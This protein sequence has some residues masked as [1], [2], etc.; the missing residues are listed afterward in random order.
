MKRT[1][2]WRLVSLTAVVVLVAGLLSSTWYYLRLPEHMSQHETIVL[3]QSRMVPGTQAALRL[4]VRDSKDGHPLENAVLE[5]SIHPTAG[6]P[7]LQL[8]TGKTDANGTAD[9]AFTV[10][11]SVSPE[12]VLVVKTR[13]TLG[14]DQVERPVTLQRDYRILLTSDKPIYQPGQVIHLRTLALGSFDRKPAAAQPLE[15]SVSD[16]KG[17]RVFRQTV[18]TSPYGVASVDFQLANEVNTGSYK[19]S[20]V[21][22]NTSSE[23][24]VQV[25]SYVLPKFSVK[26][27]TERPFYAPGEQV[28]GTLQA[29]YFFGKPVAG[30]DIQLEGYTFDVSRS[31]VLHLQGTTAADGSY[32][33]E[34]PLPAYI[35]GSDLEGG[36]ARFYLQANVTDLAQ[37]AET[38]NKSI[39]VSASS[40]AISALPEG[41][42]VQ[43]GIENIFYVM[44]NAPDGSPVEA[45]LDVTFNDDPQHV[46]VSAGKYGVA[47]VRHTPQSNAIQMTIA[48]QSTAGAAASR[49][50]EFQGAWSE[51]SILLRPDR[52]IYA[53]GDTMRL[54]VLTSSPQGSVYLDI[55]RDGQTISTRSIAVQHNKGQLEVDLTPDQ[56]GTLELH[57]YKILTSGTIVRDT[58]LVVVDNR[59]DLTVSLQTGQP[60]YRPGETAPLT[61]QVNDPN[62]T[63]AQAALGL[64]IVDESVFA[65]AE[66]DPG[67]ARLYF[68]LE[69]EL[70]VPRYDLHGFSIPQLVNGAM[71]DTAEPGLV[72]AASRVAQASLAAVVP[73][74]VSFSL[75][76][77]SHDLNLERASALQTKYFQSLMQFSL[78]L[79]A[80]FPLAMLALTISAL[81][82]KKNLVRS[83]LLFIGLV[84]F[85]FFELWLLSRGSQPSG[86]SFLQNILYGY[87]SVAAAQNPGWITAAFSLAALAA[88]LGMAAAAWRQKDRF[89]GWTLGL[90]LLYIG[91]L[92]L[93]V[94]SAGYNPKSPSEP[95]MIALLAAAVLVP[96]A[97][98]LR[99]SGFVWERRWLN[100]AAA[101][102]VCL[103]LLFGLIPAVGSIP[104]Q[105]QK[106]SNIMNNL[107]ADAL[108]VREGVEMQKAVELPM[109]GALNEAAPAAAQD[110]AGSARTSTT[111]SAVEQ[112]RLRQYFPETMLW[113]PDAVTDANGRLD[114]QIPM[115]DSITTWR[116]T[117]LASSQDGRLGSTTVPLRAFQDF[118]IDLDLPVSLTVGDEISIPVGV[119][120]YMSESQHVRLELADQ[121]WFDL[122]DQPVKEMDIAANEISVVYFQVR[123]RQFGLQAF[124]VTAIGSSLSD[125]IQ[126]QVQVMPNGKGMAFSQSDRLETGTPVRQVVSIPT[127]AIP[128]TQ[129]LLVKIYPGVLSQVVEGLDSILRMPNGCFEQT[130]STTYPNVLVLDYLKTTQKAAPEIQ[131]KAEEYINLGY[132]RLTTFEVEGSG[133]FSLFGEPPADRMLTA[134]G[135]QEFSDMRRVHDVDPALIERAAAWLLAQQNSDGSWDNDRGLVHENTWSSLG[136]N[137]LPVTAYIVWSLI[138]AGFLDRSGTQ[139]A[140][141]YIRENQSQAKDPYVLALVANALVAGDLANGSGTPSELTIQVLDRLAGLAERQGE[142]AAWPSTIATFMGSTGKTGSI[143][144]TA[145]AALALLRSGQHADIANAALTY[146]VQQKDPAGTWYTTQATVLSLKALIMS[147][148]SGAEKVNAT[149][150]VKLNGS[151]T[152]TIQV[153]PENY[154]VVQLLTFDDLNPGME[155]VVELSS[156][157]EGSLMYQVAASYYLPWD[158][159]SVYPELSPT[160]EPVTIQVAYDRTQLAVDD[161]VNVSV[162]ITLDKNASPAASALI[163]LGLPP[164]F[165]LQTEDLDAQVA[166]FSDV[167]TDYAFPVIQRYELTGRQILIYAGNLAP[168]TPLQFTYRLKAKFPLRVQSPSS[169]AY[170]YYNPDVSGQQAPQ[171][172][173]VTQ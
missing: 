146:L 129:K 17:N 118:F 44:V 18:Q 19:I 6:G 2:L 58:R 140:L 102:L 151:Q 62:G 122:L 50:F 74:N 154:D 97:F 157:G 14:S 15:F 67:F 51:E 26:L 43:P 141:Q 152:R 93:L 167:P 47:E 128:G 147:V 130:S 90:L 124:K 1:T 92:V 114:L 36:Q 159:L 170:D 112:P 121:G 68:L 39:P 96:A 3:G 134:Y 29:D 110:A 169:Q 89:L 126:K 37:H 16:G 107:P 98:L 28:R 120:N 71:P 142:G 13:S 88:L 4:L 94:I 76:A 139:T 22:G 87:A 127:D 82:R 57:A 138:D 173:V 59:S 41:G 86:L 8:Y 34:F 166:R 65:L 40:L 31:V 10:P 99:L 64:A 160:K 103:F 106:F 20:A 24:T 21:L 95:L 168:G 30:G 137:R 77:N 69:Q 145:L 79:G 46:I 60:T 165:T 7:S 149:V 117:A 172:L 101:G 12:Q 52:P 48:A 75:Q 81:H 161:T 135:L 38:A 49:S 11:D 150:T 83:T 73:Q 155:N 85:L 162:T 35:A 25:E 148:R 23:K 119:F 63:G 131:M 171:T 5:V 54:D 108:V 32:A 72:S 105:F 153:T 91:S 109:A 144:T 132:Q 156:T 136:N 111:S 55:I 163:D 80:G 158:K 53:V 133:G 61:V 78:V 33:F 66:Q 70:L 100:A 104:F 113:L 115:A 123:A 27:Q 164:G 42:T 45:Q 56:F 125:A 143:E 116:V 84:L 9:V